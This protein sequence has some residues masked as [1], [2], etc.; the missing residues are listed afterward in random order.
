MINDIYDTFLAGVGISGYAPQHSRTGYCDIRMA[1]ISFRL[2]FME[3]LFSL[4]RMLQVRS[5]LAP[6]IY[7]SHSRI[8]SI[9]RWHNTWSEG[10]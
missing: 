2:C 7:S 9:D 4:G 10:V 1:I 3:L 8:Y 5:I 6:I